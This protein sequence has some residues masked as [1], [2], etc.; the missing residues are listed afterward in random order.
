M[1]N[2]HFHLLTLISFLV[3]GFVHGMT[4]NHQLT[5]NEIKNSINV[6]SNEYSTRIEKGRITSFT[7]NVS[8]MEIDGEVKDVS[9]YTCS[10]GVPETNELNELRKY[11]PKNGL[12][13]SYDNFDVDG[14]SL[15]RDLTEFPF[16]TVVK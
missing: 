15:L 11:L 10:L 7:T 9:K 6:I 4:S 12:P 16:F 2:S 14:F 3:S 8:Y 13:L 1:K 5:F